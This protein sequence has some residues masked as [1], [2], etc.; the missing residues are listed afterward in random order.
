MAT[1][2]VSSSHCCS[3]ITVTLQ[4][5]VI[6]LDVESFLLNEVKPK[7]TIGLV[8]GS[9]FKK[10]SYQMGGSDEGKLITVLTKIDS[11]AFTYYQESLLYKMFPHLPGFVVHILQGYY[12]ICQPASTLH[13]HFLPWWQAAGCSLCLVS[14]AVH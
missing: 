6:E 13:S 4:L 3:I 8:G 5:Q 7:C 9:D 1:V 11:L 2:F 12:F 10:I 14:E